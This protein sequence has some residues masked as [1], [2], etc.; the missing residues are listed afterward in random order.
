[1]YPTSHTTTFAKPFLKWPGGKR[2]VLKRLVYYLPP[3]INSGKIKK[4]AEPF[5]GGGALFFFIAQNFP[6]IKSF[7]I[8]DINEELI[9]MYLTIKND[10]AELICLLE[11]YERNYKK[12]NSENRKAFYYQLRSDLNKNRKNI[13]FRHFNDKWI[14]RAATLI[15]L[16]RTC[17]NGLFRVNSKGEFNVPFGEYKNP[18]ICDHKNIFL[19]SKLL[20]NIQIKCADFSSSKTFVD[21][22]TFVYFDPP[23]RPISKTSNFTSYSRFNFDD[24]EQLRLANYYHSMHKTGAKLLLSNSDPKNNNSTDHYFEDLYQGFNIKRIN[25]KRMINCVASKRGNIKELVIMNY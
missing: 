7:Y 17:F 5:I 24:N 2:R 18:K 25:A 9:L 11:K 8:S 20:Q 3:E 1:M 16:N 10:V 21:D 14:D 4:Y 15:V 13:N 6:N 22:S 19:V 23:Y 12:L